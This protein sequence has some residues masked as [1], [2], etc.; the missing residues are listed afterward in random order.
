MPNY[1]FLGG[2]YITY[3]FSSKSQAS[4][5]FFRFDSQTVSKPPKSHY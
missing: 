3:I 5:W 1:L 4:D 2:N